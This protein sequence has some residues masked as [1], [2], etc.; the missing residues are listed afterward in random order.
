[1]K[2]EVFRRLYRD[3]ANQNPLWN[4]IDS[5][6]GEVY[7]WDAAST[8]IQEPPFFQDFALEPKTVTPSPARVHSEFSVT[9]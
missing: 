7:A 6:T 3:F 2:P 4:Q 9:R 8:Y 1:V 5:S